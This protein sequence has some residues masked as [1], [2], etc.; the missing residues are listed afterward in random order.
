MNATLVAGLP[1][2]KVAVNV[3]LN[4]KPFEDYAVRSVTTD[5]A[6]IMIQGTT[7]RLENLGAI[8]TETVDITNISSDQTLVV[9]LRP[10]PEKE[11]ST[12][13]VKS[14]KLLVQLAPIAAQKQ[15][16]GI[17]VTVEGMDDEKGIKQRW[18]VKPAVVDVVIEAPPSQMET[19]DPEMLHFKVF[20]DVS[21]IFLPR[22]TL[23][24]RT[25]LVSEDFKVV[26]I[27]PSTVTVDVVD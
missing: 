9:P 11:L 5:P 18:T 13:G 8:D 17:P 27:E 7:E 12:M 24:V 22:T 10:L 19:F 4:G 25:V 1:R 26:K 21:N 15:I 23:P 3:R 16:S 20:V 14:V 6:E 2:K